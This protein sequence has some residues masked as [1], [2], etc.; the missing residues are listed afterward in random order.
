LKNRQGGAVAIMV[1]ISIVVLVGFL[2]LVID[3]GHLFVAKTELQNAADACALSAARELSNLDSSALNRATNAGIV[4]GGGCPSGL[5]PCPPDVFR[6]KT[7]LQA[8]TVDVQPADVTFSANYS[9]AYDRP[10]PLPADT[11]YVRCSPHETNPRSYVMWFMQVLGIQSATVRA[12]AVAKLSPSQSAC[13][14][15]LG[16]CA[17]Q[18]SKNPG[19]QWG[20]VNGKWYD[21]RFD[22]QD[23]LTGSFNWIDFTPPG[24]GASEAAALLAE[25]GL[26]EVPTASSVGQP[27]G[28][29]SLEKAWN[30]RFGLYKGSFDPSVNRMDKT[31]FAYTPTSWPAATHDA[32]GDGKPDNAYSDFLIKRG[33]LAPYQG[34][35]GSGLVLNG[36]QTVSPTVQNSSDRRVVAAPIVYCPEWVSSQTVPIKD[37]ACVLMLAPIESPG[38]VVMEFLGLAGGSGSP[39]AT[40]GLPGG[41]VG[42]PMVPTLVK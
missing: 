8:A 22:T 15:P 24:G 18:A 40:L 1:G 32:D 37:W 4:A 14:I 36:Y 2:G 19:G 42:G 38:G 20:F 41:G 11:K 21:G 17:P 10:D 7:D 9:G 16:I 3:L 12:E 6:N 39:C 34:D 33:I 5:N 29:E 25:E 31:G 35:A 13:A 23:N 30:T 26:C 27:G 28:I